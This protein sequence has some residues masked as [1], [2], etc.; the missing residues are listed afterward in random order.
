MAFKLAYFALFL[1]L[2]FVWECFVK[3]KAKAL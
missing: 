3:A 2:V 1:L